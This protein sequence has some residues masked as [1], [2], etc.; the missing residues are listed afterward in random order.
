MRRS[1]FLWVV[2]AIVIGLVT[3][4]AP[5]AHGGTTNTN[6]GHNNKKDQVL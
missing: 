4:C 5:P 2:A 3:A 6:S 1:A